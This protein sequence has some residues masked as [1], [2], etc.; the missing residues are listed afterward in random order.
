MNAAQWLIVLAVP[1]WGIPAWFVVRLLIRDWDYIDREVEEAG[2][3]PPAKWFA[4]AILFLCLPLVPV[5]WV[6]LKVRRKND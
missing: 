6:A 5:W 1:L 3:W 2:I 4:L